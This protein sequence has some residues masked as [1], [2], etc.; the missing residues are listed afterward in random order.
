MP[1]PQRPHRIH[2]IAYDI[3][4]DIA[5]GIAERYRMHKTNSCCPIRKSSG[6]SF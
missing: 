3:A 5:E 1:K 4:Y 2:A 6:I